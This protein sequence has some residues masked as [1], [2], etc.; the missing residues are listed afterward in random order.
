M[1]MNPLVSLRNISKSYG[2]VRAND[3]INLDIYPGQILAL[4]GENGAGKSTLMSILAGKSLPDEGEIYYQGQRVFLTSEKDSLALGIGMV[5][6]HFMLIEEMQVWENI[7]LGQEEGFWVRKNKIK[8]K[9]KDLIAQYDFTLD[10]D[11][12]VKDLSMGE[13]QRVE[14]LKLL[15]QDSKILILDEPTSVLTPQET[16]KLFAG[17]RKMAREGRAVIFISHKLEEVLEISDEVAILRKGQIVDRVATRDIASPK[18][19]ALKMVGREVLLDLKPREIEPKEEVLKL[20]NV[21]GE[22]LKNINLS[23]RRGEILALVGVAGNGQQE[24]VEIIT[25]LKRRYQGKVWLFGEEARLFFDSPK[26]RDYLAYIPE[27]RLG[28][29]TCP[30]LVLTENFLLTLRH[31]FQKGPLVD[32][33]G[34]ERDLWSKIE[35]FKIKTPGTHLKARQLSGG[36]LQKLVLAREFRREPKLIIAEQPTQGLDIGA[37]QEV[38]KLLLKAREKAGILLISGDLGEALSL[39]DRIAVIFAGEIVTT[40]SSRDGEKVAQIG[41]FMAGGK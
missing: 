32:Y 35:E 10:V 26:S 20:E 16:E 12:R 27:D 7:A 6:Q 23:L 8:E 24:L 30:E 4:L 33:K 9:I 40:F 11:A 5:Y 25:G 41:F 29:A 17:L 28:M 21:W 15:Y 3:K 22:K 38:W 2:S 13:K 31:H 19:L 37:M 36:N 39:A 14:I 1:K 34:A 18:E